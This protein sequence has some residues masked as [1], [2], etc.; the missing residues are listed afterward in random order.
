MEPKRYTV[1]MNTLIPYRRDDS[2]PFYLADDP[3]IISALRSHEALKALERMLNEGKYIKLMGGEILSV[4]F[5][6]DNTDLCDTASDLISAIESA[7]KG[8]E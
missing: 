6:A 3:I 8:T 2:G 5:D 7:Q 4:N 1:G